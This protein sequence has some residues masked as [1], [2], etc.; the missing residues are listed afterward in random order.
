MAFLDIFNSRKHALS[1]ETRNCPQDASM[2]CVTVLCPLCVNMWMSCCSS[3]HFCGLLP[4]TSLNF[5]TH[6]NFDLFQMT[7][8]NYL[9]KARQAKKPSDWTSEN[10]QSTATTCGQAAT[11][12]KHKPHLF[13]KLA[14]KRHHL[15]CDC[16]NL[17][18]FCSTTATY[19]RYTQ[20]FQSLLHAKYFLHFLVTTP[21]LFATPHLP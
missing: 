15:Q 1:Q 9:T 18:F 13:Q 10:I 17:P 21:L 2:L 8:G 16:E 20:C 11:L 14:S 7:T 3:Y 5:K 12:P 4:L 6:A 19:P